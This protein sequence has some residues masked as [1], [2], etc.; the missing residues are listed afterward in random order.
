MLNGSKDHDA[1]GHEEESMAE[2]VYRD[3]MG[4]GNTSDVPKRP[5]LLFFGGSIRPQQF[6]YSGGA[7]QAFQ[8]YVLKANPTDVIFGGGINR[9][10]EATFCF[11]PYGDGWGNRIVHVMQGACIPV[12]VQDHVYL[13]LEDVLDYSA[14]SI[15]MRVEDMPNLLEV[16][17]QV[18]P[19]QIKRYREE[20]FKVH[21]AFS[22]VRT[23]DGQ[24][25]EYTIKSLRRKL[26]NLWGMHYL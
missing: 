3:A 12:I 13:P 19:E 11:T 24:A 10:R 26:T 16:L 9:Y 2:Q 20:M 15:R 6:E 8:K 22:W 4:Q 7:R 5:Y 1:K 21:K 17:R 14:F 18:T 23:F 25:Y